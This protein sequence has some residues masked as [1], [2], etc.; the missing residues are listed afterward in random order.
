MDEA[1]LKLRQDCWLWAACVSNKGYG[2][3]GTIYQVTPTAQSSPSLAFTHA[4]ITLFRQ[5]KKQESL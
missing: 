3:M 1:M 2:S 4:T 5:F